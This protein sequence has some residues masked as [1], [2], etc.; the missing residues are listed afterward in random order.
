MFCSFVL[1]QC[2]LVYVWNNCSFCSFT[3]FHF[4]ILPIFNPGNFS[5]LFFSFFFLFF[6]LSYLFAIFLGRSHGIWSFPGQ[7]SNR[8]CSRWPTPEPQQRGIRA[9]SATYTT[10]HSN[11]RSP[12]HRAR[13]GIEPVTSWFLI[14]L[15]TTGP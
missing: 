8:S 1:R 5:F 14:G 11:P 10:A 9:V 7:G 13:A 2:H 12:T 15:L 4:V 6:F 3:S